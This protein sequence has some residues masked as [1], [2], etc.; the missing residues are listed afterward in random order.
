MAE[1]EQ[2]ERTTRIG[3][4]QIGATTEEGGTRGIS[5]RIGGEEDLPFI[6]L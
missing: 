4:V 3:V 6:G 5:Y 1:E 2:P